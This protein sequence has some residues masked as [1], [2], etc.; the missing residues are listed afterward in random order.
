MK[1]IPAID[2]LNQNCVRLYKGDYNQS[3]VYETNPVSVGLKFQAAGA[4][5]IHIVDLNAARCDGNNKNVIAQ[6]VKAL[7]VPVEV[8]GGVRTT[9]D[10][11]ALFEIGV[12]RLIVGTVLVKKP[13]LVESWVKEFAQIEFIAGIDALNGEV[14]VKGWEEGSGCSDEKLAIFAKEIGMAGIIYT[15]ISKDGTLSGPDIENSKRVAKS[16]RLPLIISGGVSNIEDIKAIKNED[17][18]LF[19]GVITGKAY[20][21]GKLDIEQAISLYQTK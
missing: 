9:E 18:P 11:K 20:Y 19:W 1:I 17:E 6:I 4:K 2:L 5:L 21:E 3:Q 14:K 12:R 8:G 7:D 10:V 16:A 15:N 13:K